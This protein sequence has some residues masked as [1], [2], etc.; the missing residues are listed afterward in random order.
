MNETEILKSATE[1]LVMASEET[2][3][4]TVKDIAGL[5]S[6]GAVPIL[7]KAAGDSSYRVR[8]EALK[9]ICSFPKDV[10]F[11]RLEDF[12]RNHDNA[13]VRTAAMEAFPRY[14]REAT[15]YLLQLLKDYDEEVRM[16][17]ATML[18]DIRDSSA[19]DNLIEALGESDENIKHAAAESLGKIGDPRAVGPLIDCLQQDFWVQYPAVIALGNI[20]DPSAT[21][22]LV[23][24]LN[25]EMLRQAVIEAL[26]KIGD[27]SAIPVL[28]EI[29]SHKDPSVRNDT[30][31]ALVNIQRLIKPDGTCLPS[32]KM[33]L[34][35]EPL[36]DHILKSLND[37][38]PE[39]KKNAVIAIGWLKEKRGVKNLVELMTDYDLEEYVIGSLVSIGE[40]AL[41]EL[42]SAL[43]NPDPKIQASLIRS[44]DWIGHIDG[45]RA[46]LPFLSS[47]SSEVRYQTLMAMGGALDL[48]EVEE[49]LTSMFSDTDP[50]IQ[51]LLVEILGRSR[52]QRL[53]NKLISQLSCKSQS[54]KI[55][56]IQVLGRLKNPAA[57]GPLEKLLGNESDEV[58]AQVYQALSSLGPDH[59]SSDDLLKGLRDK[60]P[61]VRKAVT[62]CI[63]PGCEDMVNNSFLYL[64]KDP[65]MDVR[66]SAVESLGRIGAGSCTEHLIDAFADS[67]KHLRLAIV[68][69]LGNIT[70]KRSA[71]FLVDVLKETDSDLKRTALISLAQI[72]DKRSVPNLIVA[73][74]DSDWSV[75]SAAI[76][77]LSGIGDRRCSV[78]LMDKLE[79]QED[80][81]KK[82]AILALGRL[83]SR[84]AVN[85][86]L[87]LI[88]N[89]NLQLEVLSSLEMLGIPD[90]E[91]FSDFFG[92]SN[93]RIKCLL[94][95]LLGRVRDP[96]MTDLL[97][98][99]L[100][101]EFFTVRCRVAKALGELGDRKAIPF[102][103]KAQ[104]EDPS[105]EVKKSAAHA[106]KKLDNRK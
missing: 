39:V 52:S 40:E 10:I 17:T 101:E 71:Q 28:A 51:S 92:R 53:V 77:A 63:K 91:Y 55:L 69:A 100:T 75:R 65:D 74:D 43:G 61:T 90:G 58:R 50:E 32:I 97:V 7:M 47:K 84:G 9:G 15:P 93:T 46:C 82:E 67:D 94:V 22:H 44:L 11:P 18:G 8:E 20:G 95:D 38:D 72:K 66:L 5:Q 34:D 35:N 73:L 16:F 27:V 106:L 21:I 4:S 1:K 104:K 19:V 45:V 68:R 89:E 13:N 30:I 31:G 23:E 102:L 25:D 88:H 54:K 33:A 42:I 62:R 79:D 36:I 3:Y 70:G 83:G 26:G 86:I 57:K 6:L 41:P 56:S 99:M 81:I 2:R 12:L 49:A 14:G 87:P 29:L 98:G 64:L 96:D 37:P 59:L 24:L 85:F 103:L 76:R 48:E 78:H 105:E 60:S 80:I